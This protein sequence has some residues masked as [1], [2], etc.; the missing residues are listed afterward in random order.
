LIILL[1]LDQEVNRY[2]VNRFDN[3]ALYSFPTAIQEVVLIESE[4]VTY[5]GDDIPPVPQTQ[6]GNPTIKLSRK[7]KK[8]VAAANKTEV[9]TNVLQA[10]IIM[11]LTQDALKVMFG[12]GIEN[13]HMN[14]NTLASIQGENKTILNAYQ[15]MVDML[16][17]VDN[18]SKTLGIDR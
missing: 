16:S 8:A 15:A 17:R 12:G 5:F 13:E 14:K 9:K 10:N 18:V 1:N 2:E 6:L 3:D 7:E 4:D 11:S